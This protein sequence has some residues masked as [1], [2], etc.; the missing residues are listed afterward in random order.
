M[1]IGDIHVQVYPGK[2]SILADPGLLQRVFSNILI[3][4]IQS[5]ENCIS[6]RLDISATAN[7]Q[8]RTF[9]KI[10][11]TGEGI[12][13]DQID[14]VFVPFFS[15]KENG[16]GIGLS[17]CR[18]IMRVHNGEISIKSLEGKG[19]EVCLIF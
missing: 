15:T 13:P 1:F 6:K 3:N 14:Q 4:A 8:N 9:V 12:P 2:L 11:D 17:L 10:T 16:S 19:T 7:Y 5:M 18:Q